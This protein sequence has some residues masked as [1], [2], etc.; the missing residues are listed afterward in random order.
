MADLVLLDVRDDGVAVI[1]LNNPKVNALSGQ[2]LDELGAVADRLHAD[3]P[4]A[5][6]VTG[7]ERIFAAGADSRE[8]GGPL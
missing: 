4:G 1:T 7:G 6:V 8:F 3:P 5:V 2:L